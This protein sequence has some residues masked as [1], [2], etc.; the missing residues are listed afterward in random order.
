MKSPVVYVD[1]PTV[2]VKWHGGNL[3][4]NMIGQKIG[5]IRVMETLR[6]RGIVNREYIRLWNRFYCLRLAR[7]AYVLRTN[8]DPAAAAR[9]YKMAVSAPGVSILLFPKIFIFYLLMIMLSIKSMT[10]VLRSKDPA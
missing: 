8:N 5:D 6:K 9:Y 1:K 3:S 4:G 2:M 10:S 7:L